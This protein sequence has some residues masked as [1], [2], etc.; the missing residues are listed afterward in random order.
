M[1]KKPTSPKKQ[2]RITQNGRIK[3]ENLTTKKTYRQTHKPTRKDLIF[4]LRIFF[5]FLPTRNWHIGFAPT[6]KAD[7]PAKPKS[8]FFLPTLKSYFRKL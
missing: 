1:V 7:P 8:Q 5:V 4:A 6:L 2:T 3:K